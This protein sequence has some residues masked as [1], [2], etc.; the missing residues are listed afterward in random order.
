MEAHRQKILPKLTSG[1][2]PHEIAYINS[3]FGRACPN[4][5]QISGSDVVAFFK[6]SKIDLVSHSVTK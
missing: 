3:L 4:S 5:E 1:R 6:K 2:P